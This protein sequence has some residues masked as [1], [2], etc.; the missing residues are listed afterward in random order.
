MPKLRQLPQTVGGAAAGRTA[1][2]T[3]V[4]ALDSCQG[5]ALPKQAA[6]E[7]T[8]RRVLMIACPDCCEQLYVDCTHTVLRVNGGFTALVRCDT[9][10]HVCEKKASEAA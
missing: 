1:G 3:Q 5:A 8:S 6:W 9:V 10:G 7:A 4:R 2:T